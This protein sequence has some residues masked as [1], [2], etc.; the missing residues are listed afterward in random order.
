[1]LL[2]TLKSGDGKL[3][4]KLSHKANNLHMIAKSLD[5]HN[6]KCL[7]YQHVSTGHPNQHLLYEYFNG[8]IHI[9]N[10]STMCQYTQ[11]EIVLLQ[12]LLASIMSQNRQYFP[13]SS[14]VK[15]LC[16][17]SDVPVHDLQKM[18]MLSLFFWHK[19]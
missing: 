2:Q 18:R 11:F 4:S 6:I 1:M 12:A 3:H 8:D 10:V 17:P 19:I 9:C 7:L 5:I 13:R 15:L 14:I 16:A